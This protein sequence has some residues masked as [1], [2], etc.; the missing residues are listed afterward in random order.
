VVGGDLEAEQSRKHR[1]A[2]SN[3]LEAG[4]DQKRATRVRDEEG[5]PGVG[6]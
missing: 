2:G 5:I 4:H 3:T 1:P 6:E